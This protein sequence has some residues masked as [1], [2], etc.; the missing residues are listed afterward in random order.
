MTDTNKMKLIFIIVL[1]SG[2]TS[3]TY[4]IYPPTFETRTGIQYSKD[5]DKKLKIKRWNIKGQKASYERYNSMGD[6]I[7]AGQYGEEKFTYEEIK[8]ADSTF[9]RIINNGYNYK[10]LRTTHYFVYDLKG[11]KLYDELWQ[12]KN[13]KKDYLISKTI[14]EYD[15]KNELIKEIRHDNNVLQL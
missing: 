6:I 13:N 10:N 4:F 9:S 15:T 8:S 5:W 3:C 1:I 2:L 12:F 14:F 11:L 7:E